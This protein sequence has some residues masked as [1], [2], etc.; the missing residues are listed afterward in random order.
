MAEHVGTINLTQAGFVT[1]HIKVSGQSRLSVQIQQRA[2]Y[3]ATTAWAVDV[4]WSLEPEADGANPA[5][6]FTAYDLVKQMIGATPGLANV[7]LAGRGNV[8]LYVT[9]PA[10]AADPSARYKLLIED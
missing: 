8:Q 10:G 1:P 4:R 7:P 3:V 2:A 5:F 6:G 9:T